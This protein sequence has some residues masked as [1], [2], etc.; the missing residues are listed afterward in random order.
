M[1]APDVEKLDQAQQLGQTDLPILRGVVTGM[2]RTS[3]VSA[4]LG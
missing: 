1:I 3:L 4:G 2:R